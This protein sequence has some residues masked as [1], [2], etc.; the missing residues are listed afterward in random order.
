MRTTAKRAPK[1]QPAQAPRR[2][3]PGA[4]RRLRYSAPSM[5]AMFISASVMPFAMLMLVV[6]GPR[7]FW[8]TLALISLGFLWQRGVTIDPRKRTFIEWYGPLFPLIWTRYKLDWFDAV[9][10][11]TDTFEMPR[12]NDLSVS[13]DY[14]RGRDPRRYGSEVSVKLVAQLTPETRYPED[15][16]QPLKIPLSPFRGLFGRKTTL[17]EEGQ[18]LADAVGFPFMDVR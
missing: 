17:Q 18:R 13:I 15:L 3:V 9:S 5:W 7:A 16:P 6:Y 12:R 8:I 10:V 1:G 2:Q 14:A 11:V 4:A